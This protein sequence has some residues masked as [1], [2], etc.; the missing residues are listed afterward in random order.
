MDVPIIAIDLT[1]FVLAMCIFLML[2][3]III[4]NVGVARLKKRLEKRSFLKV[5]KTLCLWHAVAAG[6]F[7]GLLMLSS[8]LY[9][10]AY[11]QFFLNERDFSR[12]I[13]ME[14]ATLA[15][16]VLWML[17]SGL[18]GRRLRRLH[19]AVCGE[20]RRDDYERLGF[21]FLSPLSFLFDL[22]EVLKGKHKARRIRNQ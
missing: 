9:F 5:A 14:K 17:L 10:V 20:G 22:P 12:C 2:I 8:V 19:N 3:D 6:L 21:A 16:M 18:T 1:L 13:A 4:Q 7:L 11:N 15:C